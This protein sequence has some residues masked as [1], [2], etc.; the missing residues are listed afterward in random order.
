MKHSVFRK[1]PI[2]QGHGPA[3]RSLH[4]NVKRRG[5]DGG[6]QD[7]CATGVLPA[8]R[9]LKRLLPISAQHI[10]RGPQDPGQPMELPTASPPHGCATHVQRIPC[11]ATRTDRNWPPVETAD[12]V[13]RGR[14][15]SASILVSLRGWCTID[16]T[17][18]TGGHDYRAVPAQ[19]PRNEPRSLPVRRSRALVPWHQRRRSRSSARRSRRPRGSW[20]RC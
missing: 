20:D 4:I 2:L 11:Y 17:N 19:H 5:A 9:I 16:C 1:P 3:N 6:A 14:L 7:V 18:F 15:R 13:Y 10:N 12:R 8:R